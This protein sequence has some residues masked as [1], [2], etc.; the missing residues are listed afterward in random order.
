MA[1][2][3]F[4]DM[5]CNILEKDGAIKHGESQVIKKK[6]T[7]RSETRFEHF[8]LDQGLVSKEQL[9]NALAKLFQVPSIDVMGIFFDHHLV[10]MFPK[11]VM[12][13]DGFIPYMR[14][15]DVLIV[16]ARDP[17]NT[18]LAQVIGDFVSYDVTFCVGIARDIDDTIQEYYDKPLF[19]QELDIPENPKEENEELKDVMN[20]D[21][22]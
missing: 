7:I 10:R 22:D 13:R 5:L 8:L 20:E 21:G 16:V 6:Y 9:L 19:E 17:S 15:G 4:V 11:D 1:N 14:D 18:A 12:R 3:D 2:H